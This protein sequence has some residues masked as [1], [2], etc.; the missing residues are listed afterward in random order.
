MMEKLSGNAPKT[1]ADIIARSKS[2]G[3]E[4]ARAS[5]GLTSAEK[6]LTDILDISP[7]SQATLQKG[8]KVGSYLHLFGSVLKFLNGFSLA[9]KP[10]ITH[11]DL[12]FIKSDFK[13]KTRI[14][15]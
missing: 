5:T 15:A 3:S 9:A 6:S 14:D 1:M 7:Q 11:A 8:R 12:D 4:S 2:A 13:N 10:Q